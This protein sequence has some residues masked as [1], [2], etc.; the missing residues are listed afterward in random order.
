[1][2]QLALTSDFPSTAQ[3]DVV[4]LMR[5]SNPCP[6]I[7]WVPPSTQLG[8][9]RFPAAQDV[10]AA[11]GFS[12]LEYCDIDQAP[13]LEL[14]AH[15]DRYDVIYLTGGDP[16][17]FR[18]TLLRTDVH[19]RLRA[20]LASG[21]LI[22]AASGGAMQLTKN[23]SLFRLQSAALDD[24][25][26]THSSYAALEVVEYELL[27]HLNRLAPAFVEG[28]RRY[29]ESMPHDIVA[30]ADGAALV[31]EKSDVYRAVGRVVRFR[32]GEARE[33][34]DAA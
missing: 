5:K 17:G 1:M 31:Y 2:L 18:H 29:S 34:G 19:A 26:A 4:D 3:H 21:H 20:Y 32:Q 11:Y 23:V 16:I 6:R 8:R 14:L 10:F 22:V 13:N 24:V 25:L 28:V 15:L 9:A 27:P 30:M 7:A 12:D 33:I